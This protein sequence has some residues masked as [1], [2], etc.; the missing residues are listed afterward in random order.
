MFILTVFGDNSS[1]EM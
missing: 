1:T